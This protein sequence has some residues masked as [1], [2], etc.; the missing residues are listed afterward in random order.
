[1]AI[2][3]FRPSAPL[4]ADGSSI[5]RFRRTS[6]PEAAHSTLGFP[7]DKY[8]VYIDD[9]EYTSRI[10]LN[11]GLIYLVPEGVIRDI[12]LA[13]GKKKTI[14][15]SRIT[16]MESSILEGVL[17]PLLKEERDTANSSR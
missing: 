7:D 9:T 16:D 10:T 5:L 15:L 11:N 8:F 12:D 17:V 6:D 2:S 13:R 4:P 3:R 1:M 14:Y